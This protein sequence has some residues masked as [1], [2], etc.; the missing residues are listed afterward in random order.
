MSLQ[1][2]FLMLAQI[3]YVQKKKTVNIE[4]NSG[5]CAI[6]HHCSSFVARDKIE[7]GADLVR[8]ITCSVK[9]L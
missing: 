4:G 5:A 6:I 3:I 7:A 9:L 2:C 1:V 8:A